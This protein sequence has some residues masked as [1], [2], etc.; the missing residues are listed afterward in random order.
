[1]IILPSEVFKT[2]QTH[3]II[4]QTYAHSTLTSTDIVLLSSSFI[5]GLVANW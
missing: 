1:V 3:N 4:L 5:I 2:G